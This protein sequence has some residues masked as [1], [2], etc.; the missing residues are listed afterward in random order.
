V[1]LGHQL[2][3]FE[4]QTLI[5]GGGMGA[6]FRA[7]DTRLDR[8]V[9]LKVIPRVGDDPELQRRFRNEAQSAARLDHPNIARVYDVGQHRGWHYIVF[10]YIEGTNLRDLVERDGLLGVDEAVYF[11]RQ[12]AEALEHANRR[13]VTHRDIK[14]SNVLITP[15]GQ[16]KLVDMGL[17]RAQQLDVTDDRTASGVTLGTFDYIS[18][19]QAKDPRD[20]DV[21]SDI[22]SLGCTLYFALTGK[23]PY[24]GGTVLQKLLSHGSAPPPDPRAVRNDLSE[25]LVAVLHKMLAKQPSERYRRPVDLIADLYQLAKREHLPRTLSAGAIAMV[26][27]S[28]LAQ[29]LERHLPWV[30]AAALVLL[31]TAWLQLVSSASGDLE[32][33]EAVP[34]RPVAARGDAGAESRPQPADSPSG[35]QPLAGPG[36]EPAVADGNRSQPPTG[37]AAVDSP[38]AEL[39][40]PQGP[41]E[42][43]PNSLGES[44]LEASPRERAREAPSEV[45]GG[46]TATIRV[47]PDEQLGDE[48]DLPPGTRRAATLAAA[49]RMAAEDRGVGVIEIGPGVVRSEPVRWPRR[50]LLLRGVSPRSVLELAVPSDAAADEDLAMLSM[51]NA[52]VD[53]ASLHLRWRVPE[54]INAGACLFGLEGGNT[55]RLREGSITV[56]NPAERSG[57]FVFQSNWRAIGPLPAAA[58]ADVPLIAVQLNDAVVRGKASLLGLAQATLV[59]LR[60]ENGLLAL[61]GVLVDSGGTGEMSAGGRLPMQLVF[62]DVTAVTEGGWIRLRDGAGGMGEADAPPQPPLID[63]EANRSV[64]S[65]PG[66]RPLLR[67]GGFPPEQVVVLRGSDN[68]YDNSRGRTRLLWRPPANS[69]R[70]R[71]TVADLLSSE[72]PDWIQETS[73]RQVVVWRDGNEPPPPSWDVTP[74]QYQQDGVIRRGFR[75]EQLPELPQP[76]AAAA[77][78]P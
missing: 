70:N 17:A 30:S 20:A 16:V 57:V 36:T 25:H 48:V 19:E 72:R 39:G 4:L 8:T 69:E 23:P 55:V 32:L 26:P 47:G 15:D 45:S 77:G 52:S 78:D 66:D 56:I 62:D 44:V 38:L 2:D 60:C 37:E 5:G 53:I 34:S 13:G 6:V 75:S 27:E 7:R 9:A 46:G 43:L 50:Q 68:Y 42:L 35:P 63:R 10:E 76:D 28:R 41:P 40:S 24:G 65:A 14:P 21:R 67:L 64:F 12:V 29:L 31:S 33:S 73:P 3:H 49:L 58:R 1:L 22:Y 74:Q 59:E 11:T 51:G 18:P 61:G 54:E 71:V